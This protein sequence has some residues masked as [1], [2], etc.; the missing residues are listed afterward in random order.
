MYICV[1]YAI[2]ERKVHEAVSAGH[3]D[4]AGLRAHLGCGRC[5]GH[6]TAYLRDM[7]KQHQCNGQTALP[8]AGTSTQ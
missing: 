1:C 5:C 6:C 3:C 2:N 7:V 4:L 8:V